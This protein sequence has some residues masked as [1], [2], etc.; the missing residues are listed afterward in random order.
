M[1]RKREKIGN[2]YEEISDS[3]DA[4]YFDVVLE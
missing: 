4:S 2:E 1:R 3:I